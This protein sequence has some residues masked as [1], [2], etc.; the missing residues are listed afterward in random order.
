MFSVARLFIS[1]DNGIVDDEFILFFWVNYFF[2]Y[3]GNFLRKMEKEVECCVIGV[4]LPNIA[5]FDRFPPHFDI[6]PS[7]ARRER[8]LVYIAGARVRSELLAGA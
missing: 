3:C 5:V 4:S 8:R 6:G 1:N 2:K 7:L